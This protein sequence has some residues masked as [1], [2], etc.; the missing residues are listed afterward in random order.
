MAQYLTITDQP[1][2]YEL[3][4]DDL[5][6][7]LLL[8]DHTVAKKAQ[9]Q[10]PKEYDIYSREGYYLYRITLPFGRLADGW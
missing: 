6:R 4:T 3:F 5:G 7:I 1:F 10:A 2:F 8:R 9:G